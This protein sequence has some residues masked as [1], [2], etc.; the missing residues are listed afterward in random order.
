MDQWNSQQRRRINASTLP[1]GWMNQLRLFVL[2]T[3]AFAALCIPA[4]AT[5]QQPE[6]P[7]LVIDGLGKGT[8]ALDGAWQFHLGDDSSWASP[9]LDDGTG[10]SGWEQLTADKPW[11]S[12]GH[13]AYAGYAW[14]RRHLHLSPA[15]GASPEFVLLNQKIED[16]YEVYWNGALIARHGQMPPSPAFPYA[17]GPQTFSLG[18]ARDGVLAFR[19]WKQ[20]LVSFDTGEQGGFS[21]PPV[22][23]S[24]DAITAELAASNY[25]WL[26]SHQYFF[27]EAVI[28]AIVAL[29]SFI[30]WWRNREQRVLLWMAIFCGSWVCTVVLV[31]MRV[32]LSFNVA[33]GW[34]QPIL[35]LRDIGLWFLL[36]ELLQLTYNRRLVRVT[37]TLAFI[38]LISTSLDGMLSAVDMTS[39]AVAHAEQ[40]ADAV[41]TAIFTL[42]ELYAPVLVIL[43]L[44]RH[45]DH[46]RWLVA[47]TAF[48]TQM[49]FVVRI[50]LS[51]GSR[52]THWKIAE[53]I[54]LPLFSI[55]GNDFNVSTIFRLLLLI[56]I[57][58]AV[59]R[60][61]RAEFSR[62]QAV[63][64]DLLGA[65]ELQRVLIP[66]SLPSLPGFSLTSAYRPAQEVGGDFFQIIPLQEDSS[67]S[68]LVI[69]GDVS[70][71]GLRAAMAVSLIVGS[72]RT[73]AEFTTSP[74][75]I[76]AGL[77]RRLHGRL[78]GGF[79]TCLVLRLD[80]NGRCVIA[81]AGHPAPFLNHQEVAVP[82]TLPLGLVPA[83]IYEET[84]VHLQPGDHFVLYTDGL[85]EAR[86]ATGELFGF[87]RL[88]ALFTGHPNAEQAT[89]A[90]VNFGQQDD[91]TVLTLT[92]LALGEQST[93]QLTAPEPAPA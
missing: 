85:V 81:N 31:D 47:I 45:P 75:E 53:K 54:Q 30:G 60:H 3:L 67:N 11:G 43:G 32:P 5:A 80:H 19:V 90:A 88:R 72:T 18:A 86:T 40:V 69:L 15:P 73:L 10:H 36:L 12:Q 71:K 77:N 87:D 55:R 78:C 74:A 26:R 42:A 65:Q 37:W 28:T 20:P 56:S 66:N 4:S 62:Q 33:L 49:I 23:G 93:S 38:T 35:G 92:R 41:L 79:V 52:F 24:P 82:G 29:L 9:A 64:Q 7:T 58:Y 27:G 2:V 63:E 17:E 34:L 39:P 6:S 51:Q 50:A 25:K 57:V 76:L 70:G 91:I 21:A 83:A 14:Y 44:R 16:V 61:A 48:L 68:A 13:L 8:A 84:A 59:Y 46:A 89:E 22:V 1:F